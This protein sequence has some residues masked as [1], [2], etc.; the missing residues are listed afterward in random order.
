[1]GR[2]EEAQ[3][4]LQESLA[5]STQ[6][7]DRWGMGT[8]YR[9]LGLAALAQGDIPEA[10]ALILKSLDLFTE[11][12]T[13]WDIVQ[14]LV[15]LGEATGAAGD[16][17]EARRI[18]LEALHLAMEA[19][20]TPLALDAL[21]G[22][23]QQ[24]ARAGEAQQALELSMCVLNHPASTQEAKDRAQQLRGQLEPQLTLQQVEAVQE[25]AQTK[26]F[27]ALVTEL[28]NASPRFGR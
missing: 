17:S 12:V 16:S 10:Q 11:F 14:S 23:A 7:G 20:A 15:Y 24:Q 6:V 26:T 21:V 18:F 9:N 8:A 2:L 13:G 3:V 22:L 4:F 28:L 1:L 27:A 19:Q 5:L 25:R